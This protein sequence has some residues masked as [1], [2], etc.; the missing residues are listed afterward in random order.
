MKREKR[1]NDG[2][3]AQ[4]YLVDEEFDE[5]E[6]ILEKYIDQDERNCLMI[7][8]ALKCGGRAT[9]LLN[10]T[11]Q[12]L[13]KTRRSVYLVGLKGSKDREVFLHKTF[14]TRLYNWSL[15]QPEDRLFPISYERLHQIWGQYRPVKKKFHALRHTFAIQVLKKTKDIKLVQVLLGH[16]DM[17]STMIYLDYLHDEDEKRKA[18]L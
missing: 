12:S 15:K 13:S 9:E 11:K 3:S 10:L 7:W 14:F 16:R 1:S 4:K 5:V 6:R 2:M 18:I 8:M 17:K